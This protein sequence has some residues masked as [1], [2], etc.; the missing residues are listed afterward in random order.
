MLLQ[1]PGTPFVGKTQ[2]IVEHPIL[3][4]RKS[5]RFNTIVIFV[6]TIWGIFNPSGC[7]HA[8]EWEIERETDP[9]SDSQNIISGIAA[10]SNLGYLSIRCL[11]QNLDAVIVWGQYESFDPEESYFGIEVTTRLDQLDPVTEIW[12]PSSDL[13][14][15]LSFRPEAFIRELAS[16]DRLVARATTTTLGIST[17][18]FDLTQAGPVVEEVLEAC[19]YD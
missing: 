2:H 15:T 6:A 5:V 14:A 16:H 4:D 1:R 17:L 13:S 7:A 11:Q 10:S 9:I 18:T 12:Q 8:Q 19:G 3:I